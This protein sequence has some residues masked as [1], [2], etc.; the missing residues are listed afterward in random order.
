MWNPCHKTNTQTHRESLFNWTLLL[1]SEYLVTNPVI[2]NVMAVS[3]VSI[4]AVERLDSGYCLSPVRLL[5]TMNFAFK[6]KFLFDL[7][8]HWYILLYIFKLDF[9][10][11]FF[12]KGIIIQ[13]SICKLCISIKYFNWLLRCFVTR[14]IAYYSLL[15]ALN[16]MWLYP[17]FQ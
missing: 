3:F 2:M 4:R 8:A 10:N 15:M 7:L 1:E 16:H 14:Y 13:I 17:S 6:V 12:S 5:W 9:C 11:S